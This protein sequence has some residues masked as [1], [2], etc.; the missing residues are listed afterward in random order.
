MELQLYRSSESQVTYMGTYIWIVKHFSDLGLWVLEQTID[1]LMDF[2]FIPDLLEFHYNLFW[3][4]WLFWLVWISKENL[5]GEYSLTSYK[6]WNI[7]LSKVLAQYP[8]LLWFI[9]KDLKLSPF[10][11]SWLSTHSF[12]LS[13][14]NL[15][16]HKE[17]ALK[18]S[19]CRNF[20]SS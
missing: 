11:V 12:T 15:G 13:L 2:G 10:K 20:F 3:L 9:H 8:F 16:L 19:D 7:I 14:I 6:F 5:E 1:V 4:L 17:A 18:I